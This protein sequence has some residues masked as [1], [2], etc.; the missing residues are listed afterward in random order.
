LWQALRQGKI[1]MITSDHS[2][3]P[4][5]LKNDNFLESWGGIAGVQ[6]LLSATWTGAKKRDFQ[7]T[8]LALWLS[9]EPAKLAGLSTSKGQIAVG[10]QADLCIFDPEADFLC[11][12]LFHR[13]AGSPYEGRTWKGVVQ[14]TYLRGRLAYRL[15]EK[16]EP[17]GRLLKA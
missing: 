3:C 7:L 12:D 9:S 11:K 15:G 16:S 6:M 8:D 4:P 10:L 14:A 17:L 13:H 1:Q 2:P 5:E